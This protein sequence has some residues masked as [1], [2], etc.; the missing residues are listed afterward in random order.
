MSKVYHCEE[1]IYIYI[2]VC[3]KPDKYNKQYHDFI[4]LFIYILKPYEI[5]SLK[6]SLND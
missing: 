5:I 6:K 4:Y 3:F 1:Y 2:K